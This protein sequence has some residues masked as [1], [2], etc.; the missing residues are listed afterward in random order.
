MELV[1]IGDK[2]VN[3]APEHGWPK[4][5]IKDCVY[6]IKTAEEA[7]MLAKM[8]ESDDGNVKMLCTQYL[9]SIQQ[10]ADV[11]YLVMQDY[12]PIAAFISEEE[13]KKD[14][15]NRRFSN[16]KT[17]DS[18]YEDSG[19][20]IRKV[21]L[22]SRS[23]YKRP[24]K[25]GVFSYFWIYDFKDKDGAIKCSFNDLVFFDPKGS[26]PDSCLDD[27][28]FGECYKYKREEDENYDTIE[29]LLLLDI[30]EK[31][32]FSDFVRYAKQRV[33]GLYLQNLK[34]NKNIIYE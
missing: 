14:I 34:K 18:I 28:K 23:A 6:T 4:T 20:W 30:P 29:A 10:A 5:T 26:L 33:I 22:A 13:A 15:D 7:R 11:I 32:S 21:E 8:N 16:Y 12:E 9:G 2:Y 25:T 19:Y 24:Q 3:E 1:K 27:M 17:I 31:M